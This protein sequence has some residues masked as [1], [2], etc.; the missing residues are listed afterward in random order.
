MNFLGHDV[1]LPKGAPLLSRVGAAVPDLWPSLTRMPLP[2]VVVRALVGRGADEQAFSLG[3]R[4]HLTADTAFHRHPA[5][6]ARVECI[7]GELNDLW[8]SFHDAELIAHVLFEL[9]L[10]RWVLERDGSL[11]ER[12]F[13]SFTDHNVAFAARMGALDDPSRDEL[14]GVLERF[15]TAPFV[16]EL[17]RLDRVVQLLS[18]TIGRTVF[19]QEG[20]PTRHLLEQVDRWERE[21]RPAFEPLV[22]AARD[23]VRAIDWESDLLAFG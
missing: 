13:A 12:Y 4:A 6:N 19:A 16:G 7:A 20:F 17:P 14:R 22:V 9:L 5:F 1:A 10:D 3:L 18:R 8:P 2:L 23:A 15:R 21:S 11:G